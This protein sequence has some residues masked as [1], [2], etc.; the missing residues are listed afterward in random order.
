[1]ENEQ[2]EEGKQNINMGFG[3]TA[4]TVSTNAISM[5]PPY[6]GEITPMFPSGYHFPVASLVN[7]VAKDEFETKTGKTQVLQF[8]FKDKNNRQY[9]H[10]EW[11]QDPTDEKYQTKMDAINYRIKQI[12]DIYYSQM[13]ANGLG[14]GAKGFFDY[15][16]KIAT[17]F[18]VDTEI[19]KKLVFV[20]LVYFNGNL[21]FPYKGNF[22]ER[23]VK[24]KPC[25][26]SVNL[27]YD[28]IEQ[29][30][31]NNAIPGIP[32]MGNSA[33]DIDFDKEYN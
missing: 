23:V 3:I 22:I 29:S 32:G 19:S 27:K 16:S 14:T 4:D 30:A 31:S 25:T 8:V 2:E 20:K 5:L 10:T 33:G 24:D 9:V 26:L 21:G 17:A 18:K 15:W 28:K 1:M 11:A 13:P 12:Y 7:I 6:K